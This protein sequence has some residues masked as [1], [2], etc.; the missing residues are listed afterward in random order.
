MKLYV[1]VLQDSLSRVSKRIYRISCFCFLLTK[2][3]KRWNVSFLEWN[4]IFITFF[5]NIILFEIL[6]LNII[7]FYMIEIQL[8]LPSGATN[9][10]L[11]NQTLHRKSVTL[12]VYTDRNVSTIHFNCEIKFCT[13]IFTGTYTGNQTGTLF[14]D[15][16]NDVFEIFSCECFY[17]IN[18]CCN[19]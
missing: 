9:S 16:W 1:F 11:I 4:L 15:V 8:L 18:P 12:S 6:K 19:V 13:V 14:C 3:H 5:C 7:Q 17:E 2:S 10:V